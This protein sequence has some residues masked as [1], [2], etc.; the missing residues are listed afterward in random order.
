MI[1]NANRIPAILVNG[2]TGLRFGLVVIV[3]SRC[4]HGA[5]GDIEDVALAGSAGFRGRKRGVR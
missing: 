4:E 1:E 2:R 3:K 5:R